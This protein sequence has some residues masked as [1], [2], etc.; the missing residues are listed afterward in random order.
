MRNNKLIRMGLIF[1]G[2]WLFFR[3]LFALV[4]P[5]ILAFLL[6]TLCYPLLERMQRHV[7]IRK[8]F[9]A[10]GI[11]LPIILAMM[12]ILWLIFL[13][14][15]RQ[16]EGLPSF[17]TQLGGQLQSFFHQFCCG[18]DGRF[19]W[20]GQQIESFV[21][22]KIT[23]A[24]DRVQVQVMPKLLT[25]SYNC[26]KALF[27]ALGFL[28]VTCIAAILLEKEY[29]NILDKLKNSGELR[30]VWAAVEGILSY[31]I[32]FLR[33]QGTLFLIISLLCSAGLCMAGVCGGMTFGILAGFLDVLPFIGT[34]M[35]LVPLSVWQLLNGQYVRMAVCL[36]LYAACIVIREMLEP[37][38]IGRRIGIAPVL[39]LLAIY[40]GVRSFGVG[41]I[42][43][44]PLALIVMLEIYKVTEK[45]KA[46]FDETGSLDYDG[47]SK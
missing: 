39:M 14:G 23:T 26:F 13:L 4:A 6:I 42:I 35:V 20:N 30:P 28:A 1:A 24:M 25:S 16:L 2:V 22:Q 40:A 19:G 31:I 7:P 41:G 38:L 29:V 46:G 8:K 47:V 27:A 3:Y 17:C 5:F 34:G 12:G 43:K 36:V 18:L 15:C 33:A 45:G 21:A 10:V 11:V 9:L 44:G 32:T 37:R